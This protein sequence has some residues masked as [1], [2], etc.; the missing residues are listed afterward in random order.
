MTTANDTDWSRIRWAGLAGREQGRA[1]G[2]SPAVVLLH[3]LTF[4][5]RMW[6][7]VLDGLSAETHA[8]AF[9]LPGHGGS[10]A[11]VGPGL[12]AAV[13]ALHEAILDAGVAAPLVVGHSIGGPIAALY[14]ALHPVSGVVSIE[15]PMR[16]EPFAEQ[17][18]ALAPML[19]GDG[20]DRAWAFYR[21]TM[22]MDLLT[23]VQ[24]GYLDERASAELVTTYQADILDGPL[25]AIIARRD[26]GLARLRAAGTPFVSLYTTEVDPGERAFLAE[27]LPRAEIAVWPV[28][29]H[30]PHVSDPVRF[31]RLLERLNRV[32]GE[33]ASRRPRSTTARRPRAS[34]RAG[35][36]AGARRQGG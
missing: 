25:E 24:R 33:A 7:P 26:E 13:S 22:R 1:S 3:G 8:I 28:S 20:F 19:T 9:D 31:A 2:G 30:F 27:R 23:D 18:R 11:P 16:F 36:R 34:S 14:G 35:R 17:M 4:N 29:H 21:D 5:R 12:A 6:Y 32:S 15:A 10:D